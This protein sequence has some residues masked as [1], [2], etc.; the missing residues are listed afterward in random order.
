MI[1]N[2]FEGISSTGNFQEA[3]RVAIETAKESLSTDFI[4]WELVKISG[5]DGGFV[6]TQILKVAITAKAYQN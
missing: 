3:L 2:K 6:T 5:E 1:T 4:I